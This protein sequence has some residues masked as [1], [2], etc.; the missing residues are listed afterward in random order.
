MPT[1][2]DEGPRRALLLGGRDLRQMLQQ[3][4]HEPPTGE[5]A[6]VGKRHRPERRLLGVGTAGDR[7]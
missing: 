1:G 4:V 3:R 6:V 2:G 7:P 5:A